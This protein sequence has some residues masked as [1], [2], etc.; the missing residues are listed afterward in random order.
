MTRLYLSNDTSSRAAG[1][2]RLAQAWT[3]RPDVELVRTSAR[4]AFST[5][6][7]IQGQDDPAFCSARDDLRG[8]HVRHHLLPAG[9]SAARTSRDRTGFWSLAAPGHCGSGDCFD[10]RCTFVAD[11]WFEVRIW[12]SA[13]TDSASEEL[14]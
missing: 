8:V 3:G 5:D 14:E 9:I 6:R 2:E 1:I 10:Y 13:D 4:G 12:H 11:G 7:S